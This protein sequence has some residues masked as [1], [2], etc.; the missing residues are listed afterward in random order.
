[1]NTTTDHQLKTLKA[2]CLR[3][4]ALARSHGF[5]R[6]F[7]IGEL[8]REFGIQENDLVEMLRPFGDRGGEGLLFLPAEHAWTEAGV[9]CHRVQELER[10]ATHPT[11]PAPRFDYTY[12]AV[13]AA[14]PKHNIL[15]LGVA[16]LSLRTGEA[17]GIVVGGIRAGYCQGKIE[18]GQMR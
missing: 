2:I 7:P 18:V 11:R 6:T 1:M 5:N 12:G 13:P 16:W 4:I 14:K 15:K 8:G 9:V 3:L 17:C 10:W